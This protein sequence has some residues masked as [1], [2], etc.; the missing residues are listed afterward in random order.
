MQVPCEIR[1]KGLRFR[2][3]SQR[4]YSP[5]DGTLVRTYPFPNPRHSRRIV[6][7]MKS[8]IQVLE[9]LMKVR[10]TLAQKVR[11]MLALFLFLSFI[12]K[13]AFF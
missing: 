6:F 5:H 9:R 10:H 12:T 1:Q 4:K 13:E 3:N 8:S 2:S 7:F 11:I